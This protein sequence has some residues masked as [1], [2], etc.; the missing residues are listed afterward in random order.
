MNLNFGKINLLLLCGFCFFL[1]D[2]QATI[3]SDFSKSLDVH[4]ARN[5][6]K[7]KA[8]VTSS[9]KNDKKKKTIKNKKQVK[10]IYINFSE[11]KEETVAEAE[12]PQDSMNQQSESSV[13]QDP[14]AN[15]RIK[16][17]RLMDPAPK[18]A[19]SET[20]TEESKIG[21]T[22]QFVIGYSN[23]AYR[24]AGEDFPAKSIDYIWAP[25]FEST[26]F[27]I[28]CVY[29]LRVLGGFDLNQ[30]GK[31]EL[32]L[33]QFGLRFPAEP[34]G[35]YLTPDY[36]IRGF[37]PATP[38]EINEDKMVY[39][40]GG[41]FSLATTPELFG[42]DFIAIT[43]AFSVRKD[44]QEESVLLKS[45]RNWMGREAILF[46]FKFTESFY[47]TALFGHIYNEYYD[48]TNKDIVELIQSIK[49]KAT[50]WF[51]LMLLHSNTRPTYLGESAQVD[52]RLVNVDNSIISFG[53]GL[54]HSF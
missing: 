6:R 37:L 21:F 10:K 26:C 30:E 38:K 29:N 33:L 44:V 7:S 14:R 31:S 3:N 40:Y 15:I 22:N 53:I 18:V 50:N 19:K 47:A 39:G 20:K 13:N 51:D 17:R 25:M 16:P 42:T 4:T 34:W 32:G 41:A 46:D 35:G 23:S 27:S 1:S 24:Y 52:N 45:Q 48:Q 12:T 2:G 11:Q 9:A 49:W 36:S 5:K 8:K 54:T 28:N 43:V